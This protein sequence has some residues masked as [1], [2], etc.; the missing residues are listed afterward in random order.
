MFNGYWR[1]GFRA[2]VCNGVSDPSR[3][4]ERTGKGFAVEEIKPFGGLTFGDE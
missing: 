2:A 4:V 3:R 1:I